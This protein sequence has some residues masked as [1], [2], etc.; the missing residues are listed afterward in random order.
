MS[1]PKRSRKSK[2]SKHSH[3]KRRH[4]SP[5]S[6]SSDSSKDYGG[7]KRSKH[8]SS[9]ASNIH[10]TV[11]PDRVSEE[12]QNLLVDN[13][14]LQISKDLG[15]DS[16]QS[17]GPLRKRS[18]SV[19]A[20]SRLLEAVVESIKLATAMSTILAIEL[21][22][23]RRD[24]AKASSKSLLDHFSHALRTAR[25]NSQLRFDSKIKEVAKSNLKAQQ[26]R[27]LA[28]SAS[29]PAMQPQ[30][31]FYMATDPFRKPR[32]PTKSFRSS[33][34]QP[35]RSKNQS[36]SCMSNTRKDFSKRSSNVRQFPSSK[37]ALSSTKF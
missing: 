9:Q 18:L 27:F 28:S 31:S 6:S 14:V 12:S 25:I 16:A 26:H 32:Q 13:S 1:S 3:K 17:P 2:K 29:N 15:W 30:K 8:P 11:Q 35:Y 19:N 7:Y 37:P 5:S 22:Q 23:A 21:F 33:Q 24:A 34:N 20:L 4:R 36:Q 10:T